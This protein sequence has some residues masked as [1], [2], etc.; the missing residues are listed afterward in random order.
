M[1]IRLPGQVVPGA[2]K[3]N[4]DLAPVLECTVQNVRQR[5]H[6]LHGFTMVPNHVYRS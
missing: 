5:S 3:I 2:A 6:I 1:P 4:Q